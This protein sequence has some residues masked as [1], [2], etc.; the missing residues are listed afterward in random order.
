MEVV[1]KSLT[2]N[3]GEILLTLLACLVLCMGL[4]VRLLVRDARFQSRWRD[5]LRE[6]KGENLE[7]LLR[8]HLRERLKMEEQIGQ[9]SARVIDLEAKIKTTK[10]HMGLVR[11]DAFDDVGGAQS[12]AMALYDDQGSGAILNGVIGRMDCRVYC[13][14]LVNGQSERNLSQEEQ[15][16]IREAIS[17]TKQPIVSP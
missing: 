9:L 4:I 8:N 17:S 12:F 3:S 5:L 7:T 1:L 13:K 2:Q 6:A 16:A 15:R 14:P 11:Y 10:R